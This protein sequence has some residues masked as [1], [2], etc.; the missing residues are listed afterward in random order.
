MRSVKRRKISEMVNLAEPQQSSKQSM[1]VKHY[2]CLHASACPRC[3]WIDPFTARLAS[4]SWLA[5]PC[6]L[7]WRSCSSWHAPHIAYGGFGMKKIGC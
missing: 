5:H 1:Y 6:R 4:S 7:V 2:Q 3:E